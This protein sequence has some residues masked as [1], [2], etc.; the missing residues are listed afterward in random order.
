MSDDGPERQWAALYDRWSSRL[1]ATA[2]RLLASPADAEDAVHDVFV[3]LFGLPPPEDEAAY[4]FTALR[5]AVARRWRDRRRRR[6]VPSEE[7]AGLVRDDE[8]IPE[9]DP[10]L[11]RALADL[12]EDQRLVVTLKIEGGLTFAEIATTCGISA[13]TAASRYRYAL[14]HLR[15]RLRERERT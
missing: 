10:G 5:H 14:E 9:S 1:Y 3:G 4:L 8:S 2:C 6:Q 13:N 11:A 12:A 7:A 15:D